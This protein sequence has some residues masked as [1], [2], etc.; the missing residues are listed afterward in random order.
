MPSTNT[1]VLVVD[2]ETEDLAAVREALQTAGGFTVFTAGNFDEAAGVF[3]ER[4]VAIDLAILDVTLPGKNG[5]EVAKHL[6]AI[7]PGLRILF[8][9]G[10]V[11]A[12]VIRFYGIEAGDEHFLQKPFTTAALLPKVRQVLQSSNL[13]QSVLQSGAANASE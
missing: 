6:L 12:E 11:G 8:A 4:S 13:L 1:G 5:V 3:Q 9:S 2:D 10:H 7:K